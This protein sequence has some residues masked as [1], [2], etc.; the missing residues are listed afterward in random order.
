MAMFEELGQLLTSGS[1]MSKLVSLTGGDN[2][3]TSKAIGGA[4][5]MLLGALGKKSGSAAGAAAL[6]NLVKGDNGGMLD[7]ITGFLDGGDKGGIGSTLLGALLGKRSGAVHDGIAQH[8]GLPIGA[9]TKLLPMIAPLVMGFLSKKRSAGNLDQAGFT[10]LLGDERVSMDKHGGFGSLLGILDGDDDD[11]DR[12][13]FLDGMTKIA[14][15]GGLGSLLPGLG[16]MVGAAGAVGA[17]ATGAAGAAASKVTGAASNL[18]GKIGGTAAT[19][20]ITNEIK[21]KRSGLMWLLPLVALAAIIAL[22]ASQCGKDDK[23]TVTVD[24]T[25]VA[26][27]T[28]I[29]AAP[30]DTVAAAP[31]ADTTVAGSVADTTVAAAVETTVA[32]AADTTVAA[33]VAAAAA[34]LFATAGGAGNLTTLAAAVDAAGLTDTLK[35]GGPFTVFAPTDDAF[36]A[37]PPGVLEALLKPENKETLAAILKYHLISGAVPA[38]SVTTGDVPSVEGSTLALVAADGKVTVNGANVITADV[39]ASNGIVHIIDQV[40]VPKSVD[41]TKLLAAATAPVVNAAG[42]AV[43]EDLTVYFA[44]SSSVINAEGQG[45]IA[46]AVAALTA[47]GSGTV[48]ATGHADTRGNAA[49]NLTLSEARAKAVADAITAGLGADASKFTVTSNAKGA[50]EP[51]VNLAKSRRVTVAIS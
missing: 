38:A 48:V 42:D 2:D 44:T 16:K 51:S 9:I 27:D 5:P 22:I 32:P 19:G 20:A 24:T 34:D 35:T 43:S 36:K 6:F 11:N 14:G 28:T 13:G 10:K 26:V 23:K 17:V 50:E 12:R 46:K 49:S 7:N 40:L 8:S 18:G 25:V 4:V 21:K 1:A 29:A 47:K 15:L 41:V 31:V 45:K 39:A 33:P 30:V 3:K 37:L